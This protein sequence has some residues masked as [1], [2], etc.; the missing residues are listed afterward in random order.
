MAPIAEMLPWAAAAEIML[1]KKHRRIIVNPGW[2]KF[3]DKL[4]P[5]KNNLGL[6]LCSYERAIKELF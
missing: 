5:N 2:V 4:N 1:I 3:Q 6:E